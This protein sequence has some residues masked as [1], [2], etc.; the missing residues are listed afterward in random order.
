MGLM[1]CA[2]NSGGGGFEGVSSSLPAVQPGS[3]GSPASSSTSPT[4]TSTAPPSTSPS[5]PVGPTKPPAPVPRPSTASNLTVCPGSV[6]IPGA[7][8]SDY[9]PGTS[10]TAYKSGG[11]G[12]A[13]IKATEGTT[14]TNPIFNSDWAASEAAGV[15]RGAYHFFHPGDDPTSQAELYLKTVGQFAPGDMGPMLDFEVT[16]NM[17]AAVQVSGALTWLSLVEKATGKIPVVYVDPSFFNALGNPAEFVRYPLFIAEYGVTCPKVPPP[18]SNWTFWQ[19]GSAVIPGLTSGG[20]D[21]DIYNGSLSQMISSAMA[22][23]L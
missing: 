13:F 17:S 12:F 4:T 1:G 11:S 14:Y 16:D 21:Y 19:K 6:T 15:V 7:D 9:D 5:A 23:W 2:Q 18:W 22:G 10:W 20:A 3:G 8:V